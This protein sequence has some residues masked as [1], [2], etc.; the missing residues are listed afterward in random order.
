SPP[1]LTGNR[2]LGDVPSGAAL[3]V[4]FHGLGDLSSSLSSLQLPKGL[5]T[6]L[7][8]KQLGPLLAGGGVVYVRPNGLVPDIAVELAPKD[9]QAALATVQTLI[10][11]LGTKL[12]LQLTAK[13]AGKKLVIADSPAAAA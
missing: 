5:A 8:L 1:A 12:P 7:P 4:A 10:R 6:T 11:G 2:L 9:P 3:A 13:V